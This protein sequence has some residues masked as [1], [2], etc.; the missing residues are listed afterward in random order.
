MHVNFGKV[1][2]YKRSLDFLAYLDDC[3]NALADDYLLRNSN[4]S[5]NNAVY[6]KL[7]DSQYIY[8][9]EDI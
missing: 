8:N 3:F 9:A 7:Y 6:T 2:N 1:K 4:S 5:M